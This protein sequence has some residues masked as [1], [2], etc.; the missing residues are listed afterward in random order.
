MLVTYRFDRDELFSLAG[1][2]W[3]VA[4][5]IDDSQYQLQAALAAVGRR[6]GSAA[7]LSETVSSCAYRARD[8]ADR[9]ILLGGL[10]AVRWR[11]AEG[12]ADNLGSV[13][14]EIRR[15]AGSDN[16]LRLDSLLRASTGLEVSFLSSL[17]GLMPAQ[18][19]AAAGALPLEVGRRIAWQFPA[20][21]ASNDGLPIAWRAMATRHLM[22]AEADRLR[23]STKNGS[24]VGEA[25]TRL[26]LLDGWIES[27]RTFIWFDPS[28]D[29]QLVEVVGDL[30]TSEAV[31][32]FVPGISSD[33]ATFEAVASHARGL[34]VAA[35]KMDRDIAVVAWLGYDA[36]AGI[37]LNLEAV[38][39]DSA[40]RGAPRLVSFV[41]GLSAQRPVVPVTVVAHSY[42]SVVAGWAAA[43]DHLHADRLVIVGSPNVAVGSATDLIVPNPAAVFVGEA[44]HD[45]VVAIGDI[46]DGWRDDWSG[47]GHG[48]DPGDCDWGATVFHVQD[49]GLIQAHVTY[50]SGQSAET[51]VSVMLGETSRISN[52]CD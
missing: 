11:V 26:R 13:W 43:F 8:L 16:D 20:E 32:V 46:T 33:L 6:S 17:D 39:P 31:G 41:D 29:G 34:V 40:E 50:S 37:G 7:A 22:R 27:D 48:Y 51:I 3:R 38:R 35:E 9:A 49:V 30:A 15:F 4:A 28:G 18:A 2:L 23:R 5:E 25:A 47:L 24:P 45:P 14:S 19:A 44:P 21:I 52:R 10:S 1:W 36:P 12:R 42:G